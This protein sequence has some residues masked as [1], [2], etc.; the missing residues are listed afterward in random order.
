MANFNTQ[1]AKAKQLKPEKISRDLFKFIRSIEKQIL[2]KN[3][4]QIF[5]KSQDIHGQAIGFY[6]YATEQITKGRKKQ[7]EPFDGKDSGDFFKQM[8]MQE[9]SGV[10]RFG[11]KSPHWVDIQKS[12]SWLSTDILGLTDEN[13]KEIITN[14]LTPFV[15]SNYRNIL[16]L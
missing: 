4:E 3:R 2:D 14:D 8:Y 10:I 7:G 6:S 13:L 11:S 15:I 9:V 1:L 5:E 16:E 12:K